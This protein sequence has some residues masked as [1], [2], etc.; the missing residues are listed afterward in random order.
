MFYV[1]N[2]I[3]WNWFNRL[4]IF[5]WLK[6]DIKNIDAVARKLKPASTKVINFRKKEVK[7]K[8]KVVDK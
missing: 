7:K 1:N 8:Q 4:Y 5:N 3:D 6:K 2:Y